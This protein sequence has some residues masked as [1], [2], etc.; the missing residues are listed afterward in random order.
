MGYDKE[1][2]LLSGFSIVRNAAIQGHNT[3]HLTNASVGVCKTEC[4]RYS[5]CKSFDYYKG[6]NTCD[7]SDVNAADVGGLKT[8]YSGNPF[9]Y[10][11]RPGEGVRWPP[12][13]EQYGV[14]SDHHG[15]RTL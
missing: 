2:L 15:W 6:Q 14:A 11:E 5:W 7:L 8:D 1:S 9:D 12:Q 10:Y 3:K 4:L 13:N